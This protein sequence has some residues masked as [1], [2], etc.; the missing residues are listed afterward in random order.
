MSDVVEKDGRCLHG[1]D[2]SA[3]SVRRVLPLLPTKGERTVSMS[4]DSYSR[5]M[6]CVSLGRSSSDSCGGGE[7]EKVR[8]SGYVYAYITSRRRTHELDCHFCREEQASQSTG[9][10][11]G[12]LDILHSTYFT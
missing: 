10:F 4:E 12:A 5:F 3:N 2:R 1:E 6:T 9:S 8:E 7:K 11:G